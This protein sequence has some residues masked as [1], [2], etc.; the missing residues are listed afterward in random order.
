MLRWSE[1]SDPSSPVLQGLSQWSLQNS[2]VEKAVHTAWDVVYLKHVF[3]WRA[4]SI[5][6]QMVEESR[7]GVVTRAAF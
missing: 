3:D 5:I 2:L 7:D 4:D 6:S 1:A